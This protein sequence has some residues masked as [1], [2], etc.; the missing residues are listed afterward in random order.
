MVGSCCLTGVYEGWEV[1]GVVPHPGAQR[2]L[3]QRV[4]ACPWLHN[5]L[6]VP[7]LV[8]EGTLGFSIRIEFQLVKLEMSVFYFFFGDYVPSVDLGRLVTLYHISEYYITVKPS[9]SIKTH[10]DSIPTDGLECIIPLQL[11]IIVIM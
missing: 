4:V 6:P 9:M 1:G 3:Y 2:G 10:Q 11:Y 5:K 8:L 7:W